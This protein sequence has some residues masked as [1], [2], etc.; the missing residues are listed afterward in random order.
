MR[1]ACVN[2]SHMRMKCELTRNTDVVG[3]PAVLVDRTKAR[4][5]LLDGTPEAGFARGVGLSEMRSRHGH[6]IELESDEPFY[7]SVQEGIVRSLQA[8]F[9]RVQSGG[10]GTVYV[11]VDGFDQLYGAD[12]I[13][14]VLI[15]SV[16]T[17]LNPRLGIGPGKFPAYV[18]ALQSAGR[19][20]T[21][22][23]DGD[24]K[25]FLSPMPVQ[26]L[27]VPAIQKLLLKKFG[28][29][30]MGQVAALN[31]W[32]LQA[33]FGPEGRRIWELCNGIDREPLIPDRQEEAISK[34]V[35]F[36]FPTA[37]LE[38]LF[39]G[40]EKLT[41]RAFT[42]A[43]LKGRFVQKALISGKLLRGEELWDASFVFKR[44]VS[45][46]R[47]AAAP[48]QVML[49][50]TE[51][52][53]LVMDLSLTISDFC[54]E[55]QVQ[56]QMKGLAEQVEPLSDVVEKLRVRLR[57]KEPLAQMVTVEPGHCLPERH[58]VWNPSLQPV[59]PPV[60][61]SV[62]EG[63]GHV[64]LYV[65]LK[66]VTLKRK[67]V[68]VFRIDNMWKVNDNWSM[69]R[70]VHR[71]Y[72]DLVLEGGIRQTVFKDMDGAGWFKQSYS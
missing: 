14:S 44:P 17:H 61:I 8:S 23:P 5:V 22:V 4:P 37:S 18:A 60:P 59:N 57:G 28:L 41:E 20:S 64:P 58:A 24:A 31:V 13:P 47:N 35:E 52:P 72:Y 51:I 67:T 63:P 6:L 2:I 30:C 10:L 3:K 27:P 68:R 32:D 45:D 62:R 7:R 34:S 33:R 38:M 19:E 49:A 15:E 21:Q 39:L 42:D 48:L 11:R 54:A 12:N 56:L 66:R 25:A 69:V 55:P 1:V 65:T 70:P 46:A 43:G 53:H 9:D 26:L 71:R 16:E 29:G 50:N 40:I 36:P